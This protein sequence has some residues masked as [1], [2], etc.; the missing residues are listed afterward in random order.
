LALV[1]CAELVVEVAQAGAQLVLTVAQ[2]LAPRGEQ[3]DL[4]CHRRR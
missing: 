4:S 1:E 2:A 3:L